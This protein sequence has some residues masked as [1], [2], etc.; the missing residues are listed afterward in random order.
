M[1]CLLVV[2]RWNEVEEGLSSSGRPYLDLLLNCFGYQEVDT[3]EVES[4]RAFDPL[5][6]DED[7][8]LIL[9]QGEHNSRL[10]RSM[11]S[12]L[13]LSLGL[14]SRE[15]GELRVMGARR[16]VDSRGQNVGFAADHRRRRLVIFC[17]EPIWPIRR[18]LVRTILSFQQSQH[19]ES[20]HSRRARYASCWMVEGE[21]DRDE[22]AS[23]LEI[24]GTG[25]ASAIR[26]LP[27]GD[28][29][30]RLSPFHGE[31]FRDAVRQ[32]LGSR[33]Y[34]ME[35]MPL[36]E[37]LNQQLRHAGLR[38]AVAE[39]CTGGVISSRLTTLGGSSSFFVDGCVVY[40][41]EAKQ[42]RLG[43]SSVLLERHGAVSAEVAKAM[44]HGA[45]Q[46]SQADLA[47]AVT[48]IAGPE[49][50]TAGKPVGTV[51]LS[52]INRDGETLDCSRHYRGDRQR[53]RQC[54]SQTAL[55]LLRRLMPQRLSSQ[56]VVLTEPNWDP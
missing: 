33:L 9:V 30:I 53:I 14:D 25:S 4:D 7:Y 26:L 38:V 18:T 22:L 45:L 6:V 36:E 29:A 21:S 54:S 3:L 1:K 48:G 19:E 44:A 23:L 43:V 27:D 2:P 24:E 35:A 56:K 42:S 17:E 28:L 10:R 51:F 40:S 49:G 32:R 39:S 15:A 41:N 12:N 20:G 5:S 46:S 47:V 16:L 50:G 55:H 31:E 52:C 37:V 8:T 34:A 13:G 11:I